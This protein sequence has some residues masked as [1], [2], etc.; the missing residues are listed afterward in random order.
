MENR[1]KEE[2]R[3][4][5]AVSLKDL[6]ELFNKYGKADVLN[7]FKDLIKE[8]ETDIFSKYFDVFCYIFFDNSGFKSVYNKVSSIFDEE[9]FEKLL[10]FI[11]QLKQIGK[12][13]ISNFSLLLKEISPDKEEDSIELIDYSNTENSYNELDV[14]NNN[15]VDFNDGPFPETIKLYLKEIGSI[16]ELS[17]E[18]LAELFKKYY[19]V[20]DAADDGKL[21]SVKKAIKK[22]IVEANLRLVVSIAKKY[23]GRGLDF[24]DLI[25]EGNIGLNRAV[26]KFELS[27]GYRF[28]TYASWWIRQAVTRAIADQSRTIRIPVHLND[29]INRV[30][31]AERRLTIELGRKPTDEEIANNLGIKVEH[32]YEAKKIIFKF[33]GTSLDTPISAD[34]EEIT[35]LHYIS[36]SEALNPEEESLKGEAYSGLNAALDSLSP[37]TRDILKWRFG[38]MDGRPHTLEEV[39]QK[40]EVTRERIRQVEAKGLRQLRSPSKRKYFNNYK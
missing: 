15:D 7:V 2:I 19:A 40:Y 5:N 11:E 37:R 16:P 29:T 14:E 4:M 9:K 34:D 28:S 1:I 36:D 17:E 30:I 13:D 23:I 20:D 33:N 25:Q 26:E 32:V 27:K 10:I 3:S 22:K 39:G 31:K 12:E 38:L 8:N 18:E 6:Y 24:L 35:L 21:V